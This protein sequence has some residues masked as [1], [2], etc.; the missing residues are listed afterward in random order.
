MTSTLRQRHPVSDNSIPLD[1]EDVKKE[2][3]I[4]SNNKVFFFF[5]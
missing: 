1:K 2:A 5:F 3:I 4:P